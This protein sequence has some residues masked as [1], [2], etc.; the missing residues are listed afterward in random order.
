MKRFPRNWSRGLC[1]AVLLGAALGM[2]PALAQTPA[3]PAAPAVAAPA[4]A[5]AFRVRPVDDTWRAALPRD[6]SAAT[7]AYL[8]RLPA[9]VVE[10]SNAW[11][12]SGS[13][14]CSTPTNRCKTAP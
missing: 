2:T 11:R 1:G 5:S 7:Q 3:E 13:S 14:P 8:D 12:R 6:A 9:D 4:A 10:R